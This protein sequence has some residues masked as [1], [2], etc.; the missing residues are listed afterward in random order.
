[1]Q[2]YSHQGPTMLNLP[3][4]I[5]TAVPGQEHGR[6]QDSK[7]PPNHG[8]VSMPALYRTRA[9]ASDA[10][11]P[12]PE[13][14]PLPAETSREA[15]KCCAWQHQEGGP[16]TR[17]GTVHCQQ[18]RAARLP[19]AAPG[20]IKGGGPETRSGT[21]QSLKC[22]P[23]QQKRAAR[24]PSEPPGSQVLRLAASRGGPRN[25][26]GYRPEQET[27]GSIKGGPRNALGYRPEPEVLPLP[28]ETSRE[29]LPLPAETSRETP[30][31]VQS[32]KCCPCQQKRAARLPSAAPGS[33]KAGG[34][35][36]RR[37]APKC[38]AWQGPET[39]SGTVQSL[40]CCP[41]QQKRAAR[42]P[43]PLL[44][45]PAETSRKPSAA[46]GSIKGGG[47]ETRSGTV[48]SLK[49]CPCQQKRA[50][51]LPP[52]QL[53]LAGPRNALGHR[54]EPEVLPLPAETSREAPT[55]PASREAPKCCAWQHEGGPRNALGHR[56]EPEVLPPA[57]RNEPR[58]CPASRNQPRGS[59]VLRL[60]AS[61]GGPQNALGRG[62]QVLR[63]AASRKGAPKR[64]QIPFRA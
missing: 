47:P 49:C 24:L 26:L 63:L 54:P 41:F 16:E 19:S 58:G 52:C 32:L 48:Q 27:S 37:E 42:L 62:C 59:Q 15:P 40:K 55:A 44:F 35:E 21:V 18:K 45:L 36:T 8:C 64:A 53:R 5:I 39:R 50:A 14:L 23:C 34:P 12:E 61:R 51:R 30:R 4:D 17:S 56:P 6:T 10:Y 1:M 60:A 25:A 46:P 43:L 13:V 2:N 20:S 31:T 57:S 38:C 29:A 7:G 22:C 3:H 33:I 11:R 28:A 9:P